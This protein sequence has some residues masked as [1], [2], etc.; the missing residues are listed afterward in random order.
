MQLLAAF[1]GGAQGDLNGD[2]ATN[3]EDLLLLLAA[4]GTSSDGDTGG[5]GTTDVSDLLVLL[6]AF[7]QSSCDPNGGNAA[8]AFV[9]CADVS[10]PD[11]TPTQCY[12]N[13]GADVPLWMDRSYAW[14]DGPESRGGC[15]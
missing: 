14:I 15:V 2:E 12:D 9:T 7:G 1:G 8:E 10:Q 4:F 11:V 13:V 3:V 5:D 6:S